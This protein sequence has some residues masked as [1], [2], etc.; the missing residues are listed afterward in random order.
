M[1]A[2]GSA[3]RA[4]L[5]R[6]LLPVTIET[7]VKAKRPGKPV[8]DWNGD[9]VEDEDLGLGGRNGLGSPFGIP[10]KIRDGGKGKKGARKHPSRLTQGTRKRY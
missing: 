3:S 7:E 5:E 8:R 2:K 10:A 4:G 1:L 6:H 9:A